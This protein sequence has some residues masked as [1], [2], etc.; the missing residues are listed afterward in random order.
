MR[1]HVGPLSILARRD[2]PD[3]SDSL[4]T[5]ASPGKAVPVLFDIVPH[6]HLSFHDIAD[7]QPSLRAVAEKDVESLLAFA[8][9]RGPETV[10]AIACE[11]GVSRSPAAAFAVLCQAA[12]DLDPHRIARGL[13][14]ASPQ[15][16]P[17]RRLV[18]IADHLLDRRGS[19]VAAIAAIG[20]G[21]D[22]AG[23][24]DFALDLL[25]LRGTDARG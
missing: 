19:M 11:L 18:A 14:D 5:I 7:E 1:V 3:R 9:G 8:Q 4:V 22:Y 2:L 24:Q 13:R 10:L 16:T 6:L 12:P 25:A 23:A 17:N 21:A 20:R 15:A